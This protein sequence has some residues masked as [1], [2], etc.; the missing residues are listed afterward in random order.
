MPNAKAL[1][2]SNRLAQCFRLL[3]DHWLATE[4]T[5]SDS[6]RQRFEE[7]YLAPLESAVDSAVNGIQAWPKSSTRSAAT[8]PTG[9]SCCEHHD[10]PARDRP[11]RRGPATPPAATEP[12]ILR[13]ERAV[14]RESSAWSPSAPPPRPRSKAPGPAAM[15]R[16]TPSTSGPGG[17]SARSRAARSRG[18]RRRRAAP[19]VDRRGGDARRGR[20]EAGVRRR[21][22]ADRHG[23]RQAPRDGP[24]RARPRPAPRPP[25]AST[26]AS[27]RPP[28]NTPRR[29]GRSTTSSRLADAHRERLAAL[30][31][32]YAKFGSTP[33]P[34]RRPRRTYASSTTRSTSCST[35]SP[36]WRP[37]SSCS[38]A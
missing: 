17:R 30:A 2:G 10:V 7:R 14:L 12:E 34:R 26:P 5:W 38:R 6:V 31:A 32:D 37:R 16:P 27:S 36:G 8:V 21:Q 29:S 18:A 25:P 28:R 9:A 33:S 23:V 20:G 15:P 13:R 19:A 11:S 4:S 1:A 24:Q 3:R 35:A 22:P